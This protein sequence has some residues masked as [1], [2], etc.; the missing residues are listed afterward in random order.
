MFSRHR[1]GPG[2][3]SLTG[4]GEPERVGGTHVSTNFFEFLGVPPAP[5]RGFAPEEEAPGAD[6]VIVISDALWRRRYGADPNLVGGTIML[7][8]Q[9]HGSAGNA[10]GA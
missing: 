3:W 7:N 6:K 1:L 5:G 4:D 2:E 9:N 10:P 8:G